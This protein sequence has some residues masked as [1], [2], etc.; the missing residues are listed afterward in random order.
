M[1]KTKEMM[2]LEIRTRMRGG[3]GEVEFLE[4]F[5]PS[6]LTGKARMVA[7]LTLGQGCS[8]GF[9][10]HNQEEEIYY[11]LEGEGVF[12]ENGIETI[13]RAGDATLTGNGTGHSIRNDSQEPLVLMAVVLLFA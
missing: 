8:I 2:T 1:I 10:E 5:A 9:H 6:E 11:I 12:T 4:L 7:R 13:V 3:E